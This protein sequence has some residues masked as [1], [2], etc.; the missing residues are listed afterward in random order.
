MRRRLQSRQNPH[1]KRNN[2]E[3]DVRLCISTK[4]MTFDC[5]EPFLPF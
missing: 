1:Q 3:C 5:T 4:K 2:E